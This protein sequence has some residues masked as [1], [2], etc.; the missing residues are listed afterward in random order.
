MNALP[1]KSGLPDLS[2]VLCVPNSL[3]DLLHPFTFPHNPFLA[4]PTAVWGLGFS[5]WDTQ[6]GL[7][8]DS[9]KKA[10]AYPL[11]EGNDS[12]SLPSPISCN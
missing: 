9:S 3:A 6:R 7:S 10:A 8:G 4:C 1:E 5:P 2:C 12:P 11:G